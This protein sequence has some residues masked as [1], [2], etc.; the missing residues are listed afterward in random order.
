MVPLQ[1]NLEMQFRNT[2]VKYCV[3]VTSCTV[4]LSLALFA[5]EIGNGDDVIVPNLTL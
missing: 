3:A 1:E 5:F 2:K 4:R